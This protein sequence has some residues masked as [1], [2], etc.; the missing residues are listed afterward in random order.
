VSRGGEGGEEQHSS[1]T[2]RAPVTLPVHA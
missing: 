1:A 2:S